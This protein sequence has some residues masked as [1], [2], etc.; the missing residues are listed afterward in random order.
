[1]TETL[2]RVRDEYKL[3]WE[4]SLGWAINTKNSLQSVHRFS[5]FQLIFGRSPNLPNILEDKP[6]ALEGTTSSEIVVK[7]ITAL[8]AESESSEQIRRALR[9]NIR[10]SGVSFE[11]EIRCFIKD[12][13]VKS[14]KDL[15]LF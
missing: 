8:H 13:A 3:D 9:K 1:M 10:P 15:T 6:P 14:G 12:P 7:E 2:L 5:S 4:T 11:M